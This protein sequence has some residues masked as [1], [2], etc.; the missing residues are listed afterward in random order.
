MTAVARRTIWQLLRKS[1]PMLYF[2]LIC[3]SFVTPLLMRGYKRKLEE[4]DMFEPL[5]E[6]ISQQATKKLTEYVLLLLCFFGF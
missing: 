1:C 2:N 4:D 5:P 3:F 6:H